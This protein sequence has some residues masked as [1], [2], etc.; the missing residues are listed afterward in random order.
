MLGIRLS[1]SLLQTADV[2][3]AQARDVS[4]AVKDSTPPVI[5]ILRKVD[6][7][8]RDVPNASN[9]R[10]STSYVDKDGIGVDFLTPHPRS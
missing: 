2:D 8:F 10:R 7:S 9:S 4:V 5:D 1:S 6:R 3:I